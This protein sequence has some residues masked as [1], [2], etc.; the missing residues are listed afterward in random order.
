MVKLV[1]ITPQIAALYLGHKCEWCWATGSDIGK[2]GERV[3][4][5]TCLSLMA[6]GAITHRIEITPILRNIKSLT[7]ME[8][9]EL[10]LLKTGEP[11][12][13]EVF[14]QNMGVIYRECRRYWW[15]DVT[16]W[17]TDLRYMLV[18]EPVIWLQLLEWGFDVLGLIDAGLAIEIKKLT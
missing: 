8:C 4:D 9:R 1:K 17:Y 12:D 10:Y 18:G 5:G 14:D 15:N 6:T 16:E 11:W 2:G 7:E 3:I 13:P